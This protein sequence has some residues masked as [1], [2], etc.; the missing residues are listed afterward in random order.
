MA[1]LTIDGVVV[2]D[3]SSFQVDIMDL[4][5]EETG[6]LLNGSASKDIVAIKRKLTMSWNTLTWTQC[7][8]L[9]KQVKNKPSFH[10]IYPDPEDGIY[11]DRIFYVGDRTSPAVRI[12]DGSEYWNGVSFDFVEI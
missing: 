5:S 6:R 3:P 2:H 4:S 9:L 11:M 7:S 12:V 8:H 1:I 10:V